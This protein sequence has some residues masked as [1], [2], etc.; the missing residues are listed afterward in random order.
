MASYTTSSLNGFTGACAALASPAISIL[1]NFTINTGRRAN[2]LHMRKASSS[3]R[4]RSLFDA[5][6]HQQPSVSPASPGLLRSRILFYHACPLLDN[7]STFHAQSCRGRGYRWTD[8]H[9]HTYTRTH[10]QLASSR[11]L[12]AHARRRGLQCPDRTP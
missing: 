11:E 8:G 4:P 12:S 10:T 2:L 5:H 6:S 9:T 3:D 7:M 1:L